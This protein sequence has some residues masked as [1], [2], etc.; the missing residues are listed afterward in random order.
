M[1]RWRSEGVRVD[2][3]GA[4]RQRRTLR[5]WRRMLARAFGYGAADGEDVRRDGFGST[6][7]TL[8]VGS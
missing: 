4:H 5:D 3:L 2:A 8:R 7:E 1:A 6:G